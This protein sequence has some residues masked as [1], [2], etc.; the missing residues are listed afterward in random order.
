MDEH[1]RQASKRTEE[2]RLV[3]KADLNEYL[4]V[5]VGVVGI[6]VLILGGLALLDQTTRATGIRPM[7]QRAQPAT[8]TL[9]ALVCILLSGS[10]LRSRARWNRA[11]A[12]HS[13]TPQSASLSSRATRCRR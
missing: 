8:P 3:T 4:I 11:G 10:R 5:A 7:V 6:G 9:Y 1:H 2:T 12:R 13:G